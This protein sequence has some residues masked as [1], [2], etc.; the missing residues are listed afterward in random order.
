MILSDNI[1]ASGSK[2]GKYRTKSNFR[3]YSN[4]NNK[5]NL[6]VCYLSGVA[7]G[8]YEFIIN[9]DCCKIEEFSVIDK[10][11]GKGYGSIMMKYIINLLYESNIKYVYVVTDSNE[12]VKRIYNHWGFKEIGSKIQFIYD[13]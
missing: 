6:F 8:Y 11:R 12:N 7:I 13:I 3:V 5:L 9:N 4:K 1:S 10:Y 2:F